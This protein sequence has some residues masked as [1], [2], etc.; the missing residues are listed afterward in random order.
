MRDERY[1]RKAE[2]FVPERWLGNA[3][4]KH[5]DEPAVMNRAAFIPFSY[6]PHVCVGK[7][8]A[9]MEMRQ[10]IARL[11]WEFE[12]GYG[13]KWDEKK[14]FDGWKD[15]FTVSPGEVWV[16]FKPRGMAWRM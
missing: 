5:E 13:E 1:F 16:E 15:H 14:F 9:M 6:G 3:S 11:V 10:A 2:E 8:L 7:A 4:E 12:M